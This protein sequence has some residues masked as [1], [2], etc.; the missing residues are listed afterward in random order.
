VDRLETDRDGNVVIVDFKTNK[1]APTDRSIAD[2]A[3]LGLYQLAA[4]HGAFAEQVGADA[5]AAGAELVQL[6]VDASGLP[7]VQHQPPQQPDDSG[8]KPVEIQLVEAAEI[9]RAEVFD[10][11]ANDYCTRC[12]FAAMCPVQQTSGTVLS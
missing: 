11:K 8:R 10:A 9:I 6:R 4:D 3:Q 12:D 1:N 5:R 7:K 2:N